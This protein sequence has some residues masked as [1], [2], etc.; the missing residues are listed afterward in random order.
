MTTRNPRINVTVD[1]E[2]AAI[3]ALI[4]KK[5]KK[6]ISAAARELIEKALEVDE[7]AYWLKLAETREAETTQWISHKEFWK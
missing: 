6:T 3:L 7:D 5:Q 2:T 4:A 1:D